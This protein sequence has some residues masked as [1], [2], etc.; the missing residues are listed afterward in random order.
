MEEIEVTGEY[1]TVGA[2]EFK[3]KAEDTLKQELQM[4]SK[5]LHEGVG[6]GEFNITNVEECTF[7]IYTVFTY[8]VIT[9]YL[10]G[11]EEHLQ[12]AYRYS[13][14]LFLTGFK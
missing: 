10:L 6:N 3:I 1:A 2:E 4:F 5:I 7:V 11:N 13:V 9:R 14:D 12:N 8:L